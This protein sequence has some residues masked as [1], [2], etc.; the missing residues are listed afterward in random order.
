[1]RSHVSSPCR[2][3]ALLVAAWAF[4]ASPAPA[5]A[6][7]ASIPAAPDTLTLERAESLAADSSP[8]VRAARQQIRVARGQ[9]MQSQAVADPS[10]EWEFEAD[11]D[12][13]F[14]SQLFGVTQSL[15]F[16]GVYGLRGAIGQSRVD[17]QKTLLD[18]SRS[19]ARRRVADPYFRVAREVAAVRRLDGIDS[20]LAGLA[21]ATTARY[22]AGDAAYADV[23][24]VRVERSRLQGEIL[25]ARQRRRSAVTDLNLLLGRD[26][27]APVVL[28]ADVLAYDTLRRSR[29]ELVRAR[30]R[31][32]HTLEAVRLASG[33]AEKRLDL[34]R[35]SN[36]PE[37]EVGAFYQRLGGAGFPAGQLS[38]SV[39]L[40]R[41]AQ[42]GRVQEARGQL[43][44]ARIRRAAV[45]RRV[46]ADVL[47]AYDR[48]R[49]AASRVE[50]YRGQLLPDVRD[51][52]QAAVSDYRYGTGSLLGAID[53]LRS[54]EEARLQYLT[55]LRDFLTRKAELEWSGELPP[56]ASGG[57]SSDSRE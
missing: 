55:A 49:T 53:L 19:L 56:A 43:D 46:Q 21:D 37:I 57:S 12:E 2:A 32:S 31:G 18:V 51:G 36:L 15:A 35:K 41:T 26:P 45:R 13:S 44:A 8:D 50:I 3:L 48:A 24:R 34:A 27:G 25:S 42:N 6:G 28:P 7:T 5:S 11:D 16:P 20:L 47:R 14:G 38:V 4:A 40:W 10:L 54:A 33:R 39:P 30:L 1:M 23:I 29:R 9:K 22:Q 52:V 17:L